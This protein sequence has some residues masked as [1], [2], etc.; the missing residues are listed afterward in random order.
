VTVRNGYLNSNLTFF[1]LPFTCTGNEFIFVSFTNIYIN[2]LCF[3]RAKNFNCLEL[4]LEAMGTAAADNHDQAPLLQAQPEEIPFKRTGE[5]LLNLGFFL[6]FFNGD[7]F[8]VD[9]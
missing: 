8:F 3:R 1:L 2:F 9:G 6:F 7:H 5:N 4:E